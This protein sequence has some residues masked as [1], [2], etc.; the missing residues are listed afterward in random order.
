MKTITQSMLHP[1]KVEQLHLTSF[2]SDF[3]ALVLFPTD[4]LI[5]FEN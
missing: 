3:R 2:T 4:S 1:L 5:K